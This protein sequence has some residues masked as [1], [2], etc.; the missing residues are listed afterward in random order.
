ML[1]AVIQ[2]AAIIPNKRALPAFGRLGNNVICYVIRR[3]LLIPHSLIK[4]N[5]PIEVSM[6]KNEEV[7]QHGCTEEKSIKSEERQETQLP[8]EA[9]N[10]KPCDLPEMR[11]IPSAP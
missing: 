1:A 4:G 8:L 2:A 6:G 7:S 10:S 3:R 11:R 9:G 5:L